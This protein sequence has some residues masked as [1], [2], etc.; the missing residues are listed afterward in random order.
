MENNRLYFLRHPRL[1][2]AARLT[3]AATLGALLASIVLQFLRPALLPYVEFEGAPIAQPGAAHAGDE[4]T[5]IYR[6]RR[7]RIC[8]LNAA[9]LEVRWFKVTEGPLVAAPAYTDTA[10]RLA[11]A[12]LTDGF[13]AFG[14]TIRVPDDLAPGAWAYW[15]IV[16]CGQEAAIP[17]PLLITVID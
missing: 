11:Q 4:V 2:Q 9:A 7:N 15:P 16:Y 10:I 5:A 13:E 14:T 6:V 3:I 8:P 17:P 12:P 1:L